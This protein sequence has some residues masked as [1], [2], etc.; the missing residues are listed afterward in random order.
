MGNKKVGGEGM[1]I[2]SHN[3]HNHLLTKQNISS[4][5]TFLHATELFERSA[6]IT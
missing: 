4:T 2:E 5:P 3:H 6:R 1:M